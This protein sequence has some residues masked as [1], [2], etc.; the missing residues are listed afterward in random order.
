MEEIHDLEFCNEHDDQQRNG[1][2]VQRRLSNDSAEPA[3]TALDPD[4]LMRAAAELLAE[5]AALLS[6]RAGAKDALRD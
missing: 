3:A 6:S 5:H 4:P 2:Y 1:S